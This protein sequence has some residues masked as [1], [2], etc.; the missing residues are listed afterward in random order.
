MLKNLELE[1]IDYGADEIVQEDNDIFIYT[2]FTDF[3]GM[4][5]ALEEKRNQCG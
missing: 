1:L 2:A 4:Q 5:K 3:G